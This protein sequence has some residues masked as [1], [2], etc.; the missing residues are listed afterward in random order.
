[1]SDDLAFLLRGGIVMWPLFFCGVVSVAV[2][3]ERFLAIGAAVRDNDDFMNR[4]G[5]LLKAGKGEEAL[6]LCEES[7]SRIAR[8]V[9]SGL[10]SS[11]LD[12]VWIERS[13]EEVALKEMPILSQRLGVL[14]TI[15]TLAPLLGLLGTVT[16]M[17]RAFQVVG[18]A[19]ITAAPTAI[20]SG[21]S[22]ALIAT[23]V[24]LTIAVA[25]LPAYNFLVERV[26]ENVG[27]LEL[28]T[29]QFLNIIAAMER[30]A[31]TPEAGQTT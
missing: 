31:V 28:R 6:K 15:I 21:V 23:S 12:H 8:V 22:E 16:G 11:H 26:K 2:M 30:A 20:T 24:G 9:A 13:M 14:D 7:P 25:T 3:I 18:T 10:R 17:I 1:M 5:E 27:E 4:I 19:G 29:A